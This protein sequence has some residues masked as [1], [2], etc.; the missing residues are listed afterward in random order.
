MKDSLV[1]RRYRRVTD[2]F[3]LVCKNPTTDCIQYFYFLP[4]IPGSVKENAS[5]FAVRER[6]LTI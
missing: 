4:R 3:G 5:Q 2:G 6:T 1:H